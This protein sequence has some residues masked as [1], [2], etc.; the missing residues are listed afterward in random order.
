MTPIHLEAS[1][2]KTFGD[3][4]Y[5][6]KDRHVM[7][8]VDLHGPPKYRGLG[9][10]VAEEVVTMFE[11][12]GRRKNL[13]YRRPFKRAVRASLAGS[14]GTPPFPQKNEFKIGGDAI[15]RCLEEL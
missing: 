14:T 2:S 7:C 8:S 1:I 11:S 15:S 10:T 12:E 13:T 9:R 4:G 3:R 6:P 5:I